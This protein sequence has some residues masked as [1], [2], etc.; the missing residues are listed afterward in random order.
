MI[1]KSKMSKPLDPCPVKAAK[2]KKELHNQS[3]NSKPSCCDG[4]VLLRLRVLKHSSGLKKKKSDKEAL[5]LGTVAM[6]RNLERIVPV[7][8]GRPTQLDV[9]KYCVKF[10]YGG[11]E[12]MHPDEVIACANLYHDQVCRVLESVMP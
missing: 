11:V 12:H 5:Y 8:K 10:D 3:S 9:G 1:V 2:T 6:Y 4:G 7:I